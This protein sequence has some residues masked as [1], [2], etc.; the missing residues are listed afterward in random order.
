MASLSRQEEIT[1]DTF[2][3]ICDY[4]CVV[5]MSTT[6]G[7]ID[8]SNFHFMAY[9][10]IFDSLLSH[11]L[12]FKL[13]GNFSNPQEGNNQYPLL[14]LL[15]SLLSSHSLSHSPYLFIP[16]EHFLRRCYVNA[17]FILLYYMIIMLGYDHL[18]QASF[19]SIDLSSKP[20]FFSLLTLFPSQLLQCK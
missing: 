8:G 17:H 20:S 5:E 13:R 12:L 6:R 18:S 7:E 14:H 16:W 1:D 11:S 19:F 4:N 9:T 2:L 3:S 10:H 15:H